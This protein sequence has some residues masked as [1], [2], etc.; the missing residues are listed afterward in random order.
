MNLLHNAIQYNRPG[1]E[2]DVSADM[3]NGWLS[4]RVRDSGVGIAPEARE[5]IFER[6]YRADP[7]RNGSGLH[8]GL[9]LSIVKGYAALLGGTV[10]VESE[11]GKGSTFQ[12]RVPTGEAA[13]SKP[14]RPTVAAAL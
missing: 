7:S 10:T 2:I 4:L 12:V 5:H 13:K 14:A 8:A 3:A 1:G 11:L 6:F 9:G